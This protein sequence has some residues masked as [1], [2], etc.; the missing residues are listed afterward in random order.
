MFRNIIKGKDSIE[1][2]KKYNNKTSIDSREKSKV[3]K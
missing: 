1:V 2:I 3:N